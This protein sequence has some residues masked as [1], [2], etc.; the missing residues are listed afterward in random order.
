[1]ITDLNIIPTNAPAQ[2]YAAWSSVDALRE[3]QCRSF[4]IMST[5]NLSRGYHRGRQHIR[6]LLAKKEADRKAKALAEANAKQPT[7]E[8]R[9]EMTK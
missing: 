5:N 1:M 6:D 3:N 9:K 7:V 8:P 2:I 4:V